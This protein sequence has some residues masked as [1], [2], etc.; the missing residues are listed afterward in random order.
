MNRILGIFSKGGRCPSLKSAQGAAA[1]KYASF[2]IL[3]NH[4][5]AALDAIADME[6]LYYSGN[7]FSLT[8]VR[9]ES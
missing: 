2:K 9:T 8:S 6:Q 4:N 1:K 3:L 5:H 7:P